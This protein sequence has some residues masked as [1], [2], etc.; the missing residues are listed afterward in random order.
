MYEPHKMP[1]SG[2]T[3]YA[4]NKIA[5]HSIIQNGTFNSRNKSVFYKHDGTGRDS[6]IA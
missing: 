5:K 3:F 2:M 1:E 4:S 6:Y